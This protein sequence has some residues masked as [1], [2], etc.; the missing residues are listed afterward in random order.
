MPRS[1]FS[2]SLPL[3]LAIALVA[4]AGG[5]TLAGDEKDH[6]AWRRTYGE[7]LREARIRGVPV[8]VTRHKDD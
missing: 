7:A 5:P 8:L 1:T 4:P 2:S 6:L 3:L